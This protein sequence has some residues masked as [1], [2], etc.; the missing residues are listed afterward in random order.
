MPSYKVKVKWGKE[1]YTDVSANTDEEPI[2]FKAQLYALTGVEPRRQKVM[3]KGSTLKDEGWTGLKLR[4]NATIL[5]MGSKEEDI[6]STTQDCVKPKFIED[7]DES[8]LCSAM[9]LPAGLENLG[10]TC[11][12]NATV[13][14][15]KT[16]PEFKEALSEYKGTLFMGPGKEAQSI[17]ASL[18]DLYEEMDQGG[19]ASVTPAILLQ[20]IHSAFPRFAEQTS[21]AGVFQQQDANE[22]WVELLK[23]F[24][25]KLP[26]KN[27]KNA[28]SIIDQYFGGQFETE[29]KCVENEEEPKTKSKETFLQYSCYIDKDVR[30]LS[31]GL[32]NR[33][34]ETIT[35]FSS[36]LDRD[37]EYIKTLRISRLPSYLTVQMVRF[38]FKQRQAVNAKVLK[39]IKFPMMLD[40]FELCSEDLQQKLIPMRTK[41]KEYE[42]KLVSLSKTESREAVLK[43]DREAKEG[44]LQEYEPFYFE[45][46]IGS[47]N[48]GYYELTAVLTHKGRSSNSGHYVAWIRHKGDTWMECNDQD[49]RPVHV[50]DVMK[51]SGGGDW[52]T[53]YLLLYAPRRLPK[54]TEDK[55]VVEVE[56]ST[57]SKPSEGMETN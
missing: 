26:S 9:D 43:K 10:N 6:A 57:E 29:T 51:L 12:L 8:E 42:D 20:V 48:S 50:D 27:N 16:V 32:K 4:D 41:F 40:T 44:K 47:N 25:Q 37:A 56:V 33:L 14:C 24:Q 19:S 1:L 46:D 21:R 31:S 34:S 35:K 38:H 53:A 23:M 22:C 55:K 17:T 36:S 54:E 18:R 45:D 13:Q 15:L 3:L 52:H 11:Y 39:D 5:M 2:V 30:F 28:T 49:V 7:M